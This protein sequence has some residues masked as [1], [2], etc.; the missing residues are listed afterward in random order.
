MTREG[1]L[2]WWQYLTEPLWSAWELLWWSW[3]GGS[4]YG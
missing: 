1:P 3:R 4:G 2:P